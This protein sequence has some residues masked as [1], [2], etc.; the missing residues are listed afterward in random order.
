MESRDIRKFQQDLRKVLKDAQ[1]I[2]ARVQALVGRTNNYDLQR[3][4]KKIDAEL[5]DVQHNLGTAL[6]IA[7][8]RQ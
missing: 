2:T 1:T 4:L 7:E 3:Q 5:L 8:Q 6:E